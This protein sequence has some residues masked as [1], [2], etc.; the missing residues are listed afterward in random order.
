MMETGWVALQTQ[1]G[2]ESARQS[3]R[4]HRNLESEGSLHAKS[5]GQFK[6]HT[7]RQQQWIYV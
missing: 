3:V 6:I 2:S 5:K 1:T 4:L 7:Y